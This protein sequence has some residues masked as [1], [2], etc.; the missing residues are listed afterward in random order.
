MQHIKR[1]ASVVLI[2][3]LLISVLPL[4]SIV[5]ATSAESHEPATEATITPAEAATTEA[6][7]EPEPVPEPTGTETTAVT[8]EPAP[9]PATEE[10]PEAATEATTGEGPEAATEAATG[11]GPEAATEAATEEAEAQLPSEAPAAPEK[12][13]SGQPGLL[14]V[15]DAEGLHTDEMGRQYYLF[16]NGTKGSVQIFEG[17]YSGIYFNGCGKRGNFMWM[18]TA[19]LAGSSSYYTPGQWVYCID[20][21]HSSSGGGT[22]TY[23]NLNQAPTWAALSSEKQLGITLALSYGAQSDRHNNFL[24]QVATQAIIWEYQRGGRTNASTYTSNAQSPISYASNGNGSY[25]NSSYKAQIDSEYKRILKEIKNAEARPSFTESSFTFNGTGSSYAHDFTDQNAALS[26]GVWTVSSCPSELNASIVNGKLRV[27]PT[28]SF[29]GTKTVKLKRSLHRPSAQVY[30]CKAGSQWAICGVPVDPDAVTITVSVQQNSTVS[31]KKTTEGSSDVLACIQSNPLYTLRGAVYEIH[32]GSPTGEVTET[33]TTNASGEATGTV[34]YN[35]GTKLYAVEKTA[36]SGYLLNTTPVELTVAASGNVFHV[37]DKPTFDPAALQIKKKGSNGTKIAG[38]VFK[39]EFYADTWANE[40][41]LLR[42]WYLKSDSDGYVWFKDASMT[43]YEGK[44]SDPL[45]KPNGA[46]NPA[47][48]PLGCVVVTEIKTASG[49]VLPTSGNSVCVFIRQGGGKTSANGA[50]AGAYWGDASANPLDSAHPKGI[51][52]IENDADKTTLTAVN[53][54]AYGKPFDVKK[55]DPNGASLKGA[56]FKVVYYADSWCNPEKLEKTWY[57][58]TDKNGYFTLEAKYL[59]SGY[60]SSSLYEAD[61]IPLGLMVVSEEKAPNGFQKALFNGVWRIRQKEAGSATVESYWAESNGYTPTDN[62]GSNVYI[63]EDEPD[64]LYVKNKPTPGTGAMFKTVETDATSEPPSPEGYSF[65]LFRAKDQVSGKKTWYGKSD[66]DGKV[67]LT[68]EAHSTVA[69]GDR[70]YTF[71]GLYDGSYTIREL[72]ASSGI[73]DDLWPSQIEI[74]TSGGTTA[75]C[76]Y[77][78]PDPANGLALVNKDGDC[79]VSNLTLTGLNGGGSLTIKIKNQFTPPPTPAKGSLKLIKYEKGTQKPLKNAGF[80]LFDFEENQIAEKFTDANGE[81]LFEDLSAGVE[82]FY[83]EFQAPEGYELDDTMYSFSLS[84]ENLNIEKIAENTPETGSLKVVKQSDDGNVANITFTI[85]DGD[86]VIYSGKTNR[87]GVLNVKNKLTIGKTYTVVETVPENYVS[88]NRTQT[89]VAQSGTNVLTF[90]NHP[91]V[92]LKVIKQSDDGNVANIQFTVKDGDEVIWQGV[93]EENGEL[94][95]EDLLTLGKTYTV[96]ETVPK[97]YVSE[98][99]EQTFVAKL[100]TNVLTFINHPV[101]K[102]KVIKQSDDG[103]VANIPFKVKDGDTVIWEGVTEE[104]GELLIEDLLT[105]GK[106]Y[107]VIETVPAHY[108]SEKREQT[109]VAK[110]GTNVLTFINH[111]LGTA[112]MIKKADAGRAAGFR[113]KLERTDSDQVWYGVSAEDGTVYVSDENWNTSDETVFAD[114][115]DGDYVFTEVKTDVRY[116]LDHVTFSIANEDGTVTAVADAE[117][118]E[119][120]EDENGNYVSPV[121]HLDGLFGKTLIVEALNVLGEMHTTAAW[122]NGEKTVFDDEAVTLH[123]RAIITKV[124]TGSYVMVTSLMD[125]ATKNVLMQKTSDPFFLDYNEK[126][127]FETEFNLTDLTD[128]KK[129]PDEMV[130]FERLYRAEDTMFETPVL[131][132]EDWNDQGQTVK[133][134]HVTIHTTATNKEDGGKQLLPTEV[135]IRDHVVVCITN[136]PAENETYTLTGMAMAVTTDDQGELVG[137]PVLGK[138]GKPLTVTA[139]FI[140]VEGEQSVDMDFILDGTKLSGATVVFV[141]TLRRADGDREI[142][143]HDDL[144]DEDQTVTFTDV[145]ISTHAANKDDGKQV[146]DPLELVTIVDTVS[147]AGLIPDKEYTVN[148]VLMVKSTNMPLLDNGEFVT[149]SKTF[150]PEAK[151]GSIDLEF[152]FHAGVLRGDA[153]VV[154]EALY[155]DGVELATHSDLTDKDQTVEVKNP[156]IAT[157]ANN[158]DGLKII[159]PLESITLEDVVSYENLIPGNEY[160]M[161]GVLMERVTDEAGNIT[162]QELLIDEMPV[163]SIKKFVPK[164]ASGTITMPFSFSGLHLKGKTVVVFEALYSTKDL[165]TPIATHED[166]EDEGQSVDFTDISISTKARIGEDG[167]KI[168]D[169]LEKVTVIDEVS[170]TGLIV[171][172]AYTLCGVLMVKSTNMPLLDEHGKPV[173]ADVEFVAEQP[174]G[175]TE[176]SF[177]F[178]ATLLHGETLVAFETLRRDGIELAVHADLDDKDQT[179]EIANPLIHTTASDENGAKL[180]EIGEEVTVYD[181]VT[182]ENL[183]PGHRYVLV[184]FVMDAD[185]EEVLMVAGEPVGQTADFIPEEPNGEYL[186]TFTFSGL[187]LRG[188]K[189]VVFETL[190]RVTEEDEEGKIVK[191]ESI[192]DHHDLEDLAQTVYFTNPEIGTTATNK[193]DGSHVAEP[194]ENVTIVDRVEYTDL[195]PGKTYTVNGVLYEKVVDQDGNV[196][197]VELKV[198]GKSVTATAEFTAEEAEGY[199]DLE[200]TFSGVEMSGKTIVAFE[201]LRRNGIVI[202][203]HADINDKNQTVTFTTPKISTTATASGGKQAEVAKSVTLIDTVSYKGL[204]PGKEYTLKGILMSKETGKPLLVNGKEVTAEA[205]L[206]PTAESGT[207]EMKFVFDASALENKEVVVF[208]EIYRAETLIAEHKD[209]EDKDQTV[210]FVPK[211]PELPKTGDF[212]PLAY[213]LWGGGLV[214]SGL[215]LL[216]FLRKKRRTTE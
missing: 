166:I 82:Y 87:S 41:R 11:E 148:G 78:I 6:P 28:S 204:V 44:A 142:A 181:V 31:L 93:T 42:T 215:S 97:N 209:I 17:F 127:V 101:V 168:A 131:I 94:L 50:A 38:A 91:I 125:K 123:E 89:F 45:F 201:T 134:A 95:I 54:P 36:P 33:L 193:E 133:V 62:Y 75:A 92:K 53:K 63:L 32:K 192:Y 106:T 27:Y 175:S 14:P 4:D 128:Q 163:T 129:L 153:V 109:F 159:D 67:Y 104:N 216:V 214:L 164:S 107:T 205:K 177:T 208:E 195:I 86:T 19:S 26:K 81:I 121:I 197:E 58:A 64:T 12:D 182:Y 194:I 144:S 71:T 56:I 156:V 84:E 29:A 72:I 113:F 147:Y 190:L 137:T 135:T 30:V 140:G 149:A 171:G 188:K 73:T 105:I 160:E 167:G 184:G 52:K 212:G 70:D 7:T 10:S 110:L 23:E 111:P 65:N 203:V 108:L 49:Y 22:T 85:K 169:P 39:A 115:R 178:N 180:Y 196:Q 55:I 130:V 173:S 66:A 150:I 136:L 43:T 51:Y 40:D 117:A 88:D 161:R 2:L 90:V 48:F 61:K 146:V 20:Y 143:K 157:T 141:E 151:D 79:A 170:Y 191:A 8:A 69:P 16:T 102:L 162:E 211:A 185:E 187:D 83:Q 172:K 138:D 98:K 152:T 76:H 21:D 37:K 112:K 100:G 158:E 80:R 132:H 5:W 154:F 122:Q 198:N 124:R 179:V 47:S 18:A 57:F 213:W 114:F 199:V 200:F 207:A 120:A 25:T 210:F 74:T 60:E 206:V 183:I 15:P 186:M 1:M 202:A 189:L 77:V 174:D 103:N 24:S 155:R 46:N 3:A 35:I 59:A 139:S 34:K 68:D 9:E 145:T 119:F 13:G 176:L 126:N 96:I 99:R 118:V 165:K 116:S